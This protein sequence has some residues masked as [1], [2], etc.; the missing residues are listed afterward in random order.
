M[1]FINSNGYVIQ[2]SIAPVI[3]PEIKANKGDISFLLVDIS[4]F[5]KIFEI[6][7]FLN[8]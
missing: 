8:N 6:L 2:I 3:N 7:N 5:L 4:L 1:V